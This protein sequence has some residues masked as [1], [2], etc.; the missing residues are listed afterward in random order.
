MTQAV[1]VSV[2]CQLYTAWSCLCA[3][4]L[5]EARIL[6]ITT[7]TVNTLAHIVKSDEPP[8]RCSDGDSVR[9]ITMNYVIGDPENEYRQ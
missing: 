9:V 1:Q 6:P 5:Q 4:L 8:L 7:I 3:E 2:S